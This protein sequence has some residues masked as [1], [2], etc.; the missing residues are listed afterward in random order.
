M[1]ALLLLLEQ[2]EC[3]SHDETD[4]ISRRSVHAKLGVSQGRNSGLAVIPGLVEAFVVQ[5]KVH[6]VPD[7]FRDAQVEHIQTTLAR[8]T[9]RSEPSSMYPLTWR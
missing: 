8:G 5:V 3:E 6:A 9:V 2:S 7:A 1:P 4:G